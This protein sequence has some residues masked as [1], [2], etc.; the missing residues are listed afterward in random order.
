[1][2]SNKTFKKGARTSINDP[3]VNASELFDNPLGLTL[4]ICS[5]SICL[6]SSS[7]CSSNASTK[8]FLKWNETKNGNETSNHRYKIPFLQKSV[9]C[10]DAPLFIS[11]KLNAFH[12]YTMQ[13]DRMISCAH[14]RIQ[15]VL[16]CI[17][18]DF[19]KCIG[20]LCA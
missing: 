19:I 14:N 2:L 16:C 3:I 1:M 9:Q 5:P 11:N 20:Y 13:V 12:A 15:E 17:A 10:M 6:V 4:S 18:V 8:M 7:V